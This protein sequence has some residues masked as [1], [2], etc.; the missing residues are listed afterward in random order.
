MAIDE[1]LKDILKGLQRIY[2]Q[3]V[4]Q[5]QFKYSVCKDLQILKIH[6][7]SFLKYYMITRNKFSK[8]EISSSLRV[9]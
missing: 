8:F 7:A 1:F 4:F 5:T 9:S 2:E 6:N 3:T